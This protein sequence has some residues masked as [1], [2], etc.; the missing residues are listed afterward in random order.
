[1]K[2]SFLRGY[3]GQP[4][5]A[6]K[7]TY[8]VAIGT[9]RSWKDTKGE[10]INKTDWVTVTILNAKIAKWVMAN[11]KKVD[12]VYAECRVAE[13]SYKKAGEKIYTTDIIANMFDSLVHKP[14]PMNGRALSGC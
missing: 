6:V 8:K 4:P 10:I 2:L 3:A 1:L 9:T 14:I 13:G 12:P 11:V 5:K 7:E